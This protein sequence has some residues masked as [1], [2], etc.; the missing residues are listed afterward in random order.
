VVDARRAAPA[1]AA[2]GLVVLMM[3]AGLLAPTDGVDAQEVVATVTVPDAFRPVVNPT[4]NRVYVGNSVIDGATN[5]VVGTLPVPGGVVAVNPA[6]NRLYVAS[7]GVVSVLDGATNT[8]VGTLPVAATEVAVNPTTNR[9]YVR[10]VSGFVVVDGATNAV[11]TTFQV[12]SRPASRRPAAWWSTR[13]P[14]ASTR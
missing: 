13:P 8:V 6:T 1:M 3:L 9:L 11:V 2:L 12:P 4:T 7:D 10:N 14:T 5:T